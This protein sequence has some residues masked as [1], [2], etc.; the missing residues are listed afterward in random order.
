MIKAVLFDLDDTLLDYMG[1]REECI[2]EAV[3]GMREAGL[4]MP[5]KEAY[6]RLKKV[7]WD[8]GLDS[9]DA[10]SS[11][12]KKVGKVDDYRILAAGVN[13]Y[14]D[15]R[16]ENTRPV[17]GAISTVKWLKK[18]GVKV[19]IVTDAP[20]IKAWTRLN[21]MRMDGLFPL[22]VTPDDT[23]VKKPDPKPFLTAMKALGVKPS[24]TVM[25]GD[26]PERDIEGAVSLHMVSVLISFRFKKRKG[27][28][29]YRINEMYELIDVIDGLM[30]EED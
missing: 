6:K 17:E 11:F 25:V 27:K 30:E 22:V 14:T 12:L 23:G 24:E 7:H 10:V 18:R 28:E 20:K 9:D 1:M 19:A 21:L 5:Y 15:A 26:W 8:V 4:D 29:D 16:I 2:E 3:R 13:A